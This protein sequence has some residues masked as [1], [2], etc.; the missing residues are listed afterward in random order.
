MK[1][2]IWC[3]LFFGLSLCPL[4]WPRA[5]AAQ[6]EGYRA[7]IEIRGGGPG[8]EIVPFCEAPLEG[9]VRYQLVTRKK[10]RSGTSSSTQSGRVSLKAGE[11]KGL[12]RVG[13]N[14]QPGDEYRLHLKI[15]KDGRVVAEE[16]KSLSGSTLQFET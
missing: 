13:L 5:G 10:G 15:F 6:E 3:L 11:K 2:G 1:T 9:Q 12:C 8:M 4:V 7:W 16:K 14:I